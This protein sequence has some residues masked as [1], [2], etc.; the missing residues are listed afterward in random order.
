[1]GNDNPDFKEFSRRREQMYDIAE[2]RWNN[3]AGSERVDQED[4]ELVRKRLAYHKAAERVRK[5]NRRRKEANN[6][7]HSKPASPLPPE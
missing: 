7:S 6:S 2:A 1:M 3:V 5:M 4:K